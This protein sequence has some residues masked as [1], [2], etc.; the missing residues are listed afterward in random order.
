MSFLDDL[1]IKRKKF[2]DGLEANQGDIDLDI[3]EDFYPDKAHF[4]YELL[5]NAEDANASNVR[6][7]LSEKSLVCEHDGR[8]FDEADIKAITGIGAGTKREDDD[9]IGRFG[10]GFKPGYCTKPEVDDFG[11]LYGPARRVF[12]W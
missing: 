9:K 1:R 10:I 12:G 3:F 11:V 8:S 2:L 4:I 6:F 7:V 5:Q